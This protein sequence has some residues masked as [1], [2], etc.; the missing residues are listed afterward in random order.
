MNFRSI[1]SIAFVT[2]SIALQGSACTTTVEQGTSDSVGASAASTGNIV[3]MGPCDQ[4]QDTCFV[5]TSDGTDTIMG[6]CAYGDHVAVCCTG[7]IDAQGSCQQGM[8]DVGACGMG[9]NACNVCAV[10]PRSDAVAC[11]QAACIVSE[12]VWA[13]SPTGTPCKADGEGGHTCNGNGVCQD[14]DVQCKTTADCPTPPECH[15]TRCNDTIGPRHGK[16]DVFA[17][18]DGNECTLG[19]CA[20]VTSGYSADLCASLNP[21]SLAYLCDGKN[22]P[23]L[24]NGVCNQP[25]SANYPDTWCCDLVK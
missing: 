25:D 7:C 22:G 1:A 10:V 16:C 3:H 11:L 8:S 14:L 5:P 20:I 24:G 2:I 6:H 12:C 4:G 21:K 18:T 17:Y 13:P 9:G 15:E 23:V 19:I